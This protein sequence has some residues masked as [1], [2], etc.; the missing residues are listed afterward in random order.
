MSPLDL[1]YE[2]H[3]VAII[4]EVGTR[5]DAWHLLLPQGSVLTGSGR[6]EERP[7]Y[8]P[9]PAPLPSYETQQLLILLAS[10]RLA[11]YPHY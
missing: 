10:D 1:V 5:S 6:G 3:E 8:S 2:L 9:R 7:N 4:P 11:W